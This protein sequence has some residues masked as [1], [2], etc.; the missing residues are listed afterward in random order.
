MTQQEFHQL[1]TRYLEGKATAEEEKLLL[2]WHA[3][4]SSQP[5]EGLANSEEQAIGRRMW[6]R[7][8]PQLHPR[9]VLTRWVAPWVWATG[10]AACL[11]L[12]LYGLLTTTKRPLLV[13]PDEQRTAAQ[14]VGVV[15]KNTTATEQKV[16][17]AD[18]TLVWLQRNS[19]LVCDKAFNQSRRDVYLQGEAFFSV[20][21]NEVKPFRVHVGALVTEVLGT[22]FRIKP[23]ANTI[24]VAVTSGKVSVYNNRFNTSRQR[25]GVILTPNQRVVFDVLTQ[26][27]TQS[28]I[29]EPVP[30]TVSGANS[31]SLVF[32]MAPLQT[33]LAAL[34]K[35][36]GIEF[37]IANP[38]MKDCLITADISDLP[39]F[40]QLELICKSIDATYEKR[41]TVVFIEGDG[42]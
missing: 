28:L 20:K 5:I 36:Y 11:L 6:Q 33:V 29:D 40:T 35:Q 19:S 42:C 22:S 38:K 7:I 16:Q 2:D 10:L 37:M 14:Q 3:S 24:E 30:L 26:H 18:G 12:G 39:L 13:N 8:H 21:R 9:P 32:R 34:S 15:M 17:L 4:Q 23:H 41:G 25:N 1:S 31:P 27:M